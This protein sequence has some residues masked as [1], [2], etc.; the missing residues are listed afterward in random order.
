MRS[1]CATS[2]PRSAVRPSPPPACMQHDVIQGLYI[3]VCTARTCT[4]EGPH[5]RNVPWCGTAQVAS[6]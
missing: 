6:G 1:R 4:H 3:L 5:D 2:G